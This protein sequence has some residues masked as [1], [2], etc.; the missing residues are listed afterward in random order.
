MWGLEGWKEDVF[1][2]NRSFC[3]KL[4]PRGNVRGGLRTLRLDEGH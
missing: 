2:G 1:Y 3:V 4:V